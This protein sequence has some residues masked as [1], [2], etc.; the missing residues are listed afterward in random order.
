MEVDMSEPSRNNPMRDPGQMTFDFFKEIPGKEASARYTVDVFSSGQG[1]LSGCPSCSYEWED[2]GDIANLIHNMTRRDCSS[3]LIRIWINEK[4]DR[5][6]ADP[7]DEM[8]DHY[9][10]NGLLMGDPDRDPEE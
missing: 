6:Y 8:Y 3:R 1:E 4:D 5:P 9:E 7:D 10:S 2:I